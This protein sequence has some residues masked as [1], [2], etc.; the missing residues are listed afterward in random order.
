MTEH[1]IHKRLLRHIGR[2][3]IDEGIAQMSVVV[4]LDIVEDSIVIVRH[5]VV[6]LGACLNGKCTRCTRV[7]RT[8]SGKRGGKLIE[9]FLVEVDFKS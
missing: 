2:G 3:R 5:E 7:L 8:G 4:H 6:Q 1:Y 9:I